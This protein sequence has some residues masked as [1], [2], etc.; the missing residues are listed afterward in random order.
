[1]NKALTR[2]HDIDLRQRGDAQLCH[3]KQMKPGLAQLRT[4]LS[5]IVL[6]AGS[7]V[8]VAGFAGQSSGLGA[9]FGAV[10]DVAASSINGSSQA[11]GH[12][13]ATAQHHHDGCCEHPDCAYSSGSGCC[14][15]YIFAAG[16]C[17]VIHCAPS[18]TRFVAGKAFLA[19]G[20]DPEA[21]LQPPQIFV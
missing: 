9:N 21:L 14:A 6:V 12:V 13:A 3:A 5:V 8:A 19:T 15:A 2:G 4:L 11:A 7:I 18:T 1:M 16:E 10:A 20:I 17:A